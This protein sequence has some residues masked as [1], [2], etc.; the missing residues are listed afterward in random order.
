VFDFVDKCW[1]D[2]LLLDVS[3]LANRPLPLALR[4]VIDYIQ[5]NVF[6]NLIQ[7]GCGHLVECKLVLNFRGNE[8][9]DKEAL[10]QFLLEK[11][12]ILHTFYELDRVV[13]LENH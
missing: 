3:D 2:L 8:L 12:S 7:S 1:I 6:E 10:F 4:N 11:S 9:L 5:C 13:T